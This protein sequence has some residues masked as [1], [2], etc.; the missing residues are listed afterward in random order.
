MKR[1][2]KTKALL[3]A[4][5]SGGIAASVMSQPNGSGEL[6]ECIS[7]YPPPSQ[8]NNL[9]TS[10]NS[11]GD[12]RAFCDKVR[13]Q[14]KMGGKKN[15][16]YKTTSPRLCGRGQYCV[17]DATSSLPGPGGTTLAGAWDCQ[18]GD[19]G[20]GGRAGELTYDDNET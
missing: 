1:N 12:S 2:W 3:I 14:I 19:H 13:S 10:G 17:W 16:K 7:T 5:T 6:I 8:I 11:H 4:A 20:C 9:P 18:A 15:A